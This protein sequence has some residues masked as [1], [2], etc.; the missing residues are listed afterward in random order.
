MGV[1]RLHTSDAR[2]GAFVGVIS[3]V[4]SIALLLGAGDQDSLAR[5][6]HVSGLVSYGLVLGAA[7]LTYFHWRMVSVTRG[8]GLAPRLGG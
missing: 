5:M 1:A 8:G 3:T 7:V 2:V 6:V 4:P